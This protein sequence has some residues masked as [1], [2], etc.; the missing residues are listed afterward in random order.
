MMV[1]AVFFS[2]ITVVPRNLTP[3]KDIEP[4]IIEALSKMRKTD[5]TTTNCT[6]KIK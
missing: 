5:W 3:A 6:I 4:K 1:A 2:R